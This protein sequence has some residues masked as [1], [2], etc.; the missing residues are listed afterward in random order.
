M[1]IDLLA[2]NV[3]AIVRRIT[4]SQLSRYDR[5]Q[6]SLCA[7]DVTADPDYQR[8]FNGYYRMQRKRREWYGYFFS[9]LEREKRNRNTTFRDVF[10]ETYSTKHRVEPSFSSKLVATIRPE[11][12]IFDRENLCL[13][14]PGQQKAAQVRV[15][16]F[17][18]AYSTLESKV[19]A[20]IQNPI[21]IK[22]LRP[23]LDK[24]FLS[25]AHFTD[26]KKL[27]LLLWQY[28]LD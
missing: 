22:E 16:E 15:R 6:R 10:E 26:V 8:M 4:V 28:R 9:L 23:L 18:A 21:F 24:T 17:I 1:I 2:S 19:A 20:L 27:D 3:E 5:L 7:T 11:V 13:T 12:P 25:Y 14:V